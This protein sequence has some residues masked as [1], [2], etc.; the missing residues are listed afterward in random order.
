MGCGGSKSDAQAPTTTTTQPKQT[1]A[2]PAQSTSAD[3]ELE[4]EVNAKRVNKQGVEVSQYDR[5]EQRPEDNTAM[6]GLFEM[7]SAGSGE[8]ALAIKPWIGAIKAPSNPPAWQNQAP[9]VNLHLEYAYGYRC[10]DSRQ[11]LFYSSNPNHIVYMTAALGVVLDKTNNTQKLFGAGHIKQANGHSDDITALAISADRNLVATG[12]VGAN[13]KVLIWSPSNPEAAPRASIQLGRGKRAVSCLGF[14]SDGQYLAVADMHNDHNISVW[15]VSTGRKIAEAKGSQDKILDLAWSHNEHRFCSTGIKHIAFWT[16]QNGQ[17]SQEKGLFGAQGAQTNMTSVQWF[18][19]NTAVTGGA[20]GM[21][22]HWQGRDLKKAVQVHAPNQAIHALAIVNDVILSG[23]KDNKII[24]LDK[25]FQ[26]TKEI[27]AGSCPKSLD[28]QGSNILAGLRDGSIKEFAASGSATT[29]MESHSDGE[30]WGLAIDPSNPN[31]IVTSADDNRI[32]AWDTTQRRCIGSGT[33][34]SARGEE[35]KA[36]AGASTMANT[37]QNQQARSV[38]IHPQNGHVAVG[39]N[40]GRITV[41]AGVRSLDNIAFTLRDPKEWIEVIR[42]SPDG[43]KLAVGSHDNSIYIYN[44]SQN[45]KLVHKLSK[46]SSYI[47]SLD[48]SVDGNALH[49]TC[50][51]YE[52]LF[53]DITS[54]HQ[55]TDGATRFADEHWATWSTHFG[56]PVQGIYGGVVDLTHVNRVDR[57]AHGDLVAVGNDWG[58]VEVF[59]YPNNAGAKSQ[60]FRAHSEHV[61]NVKWSHDDRKLFSA[62]GYDQTIMQ[63][64]RV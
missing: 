17:L 31:V 6:V 54:G 2:K 7:E 41:R 14:S 11:N 30:V 58:L 42:Y 64:A 39:H 45:Y 33:I 16:L 35:R 53:W 47:I 29:L 1:V 37:T 5:N 43:S 22:Y 48:W 12:E 24:V 55:V 36:G 10:F 23:G 26:K 15:E 34:D 63:W 18:S 3:E 49:S 51:S 28:H 27:N 9:S 59:G 46:H 13:P 40:D 44:V 56:W 21:L 38:A 8:Q 50:A 25:N 62:G 20:N 19:D 52:L 60:A 57:S 4:R 32:K 61:M